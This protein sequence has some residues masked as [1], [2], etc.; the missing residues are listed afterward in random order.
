VISLSLPSSA[1]PTA[2]DAVLLEQL[3]A[4]GAQVGGREKLRQLQ[5][6]PAHHVSCLARDPNPS[7]QIDAE[8]SKKESGDETSQP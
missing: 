6:T 3:G 2:P 7:D 8:A 4:L 1:P 5:I